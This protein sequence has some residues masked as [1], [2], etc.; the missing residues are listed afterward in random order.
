MSEA[1]RR[2]L[3]P[4]GDVNPR[5]G[6]SEL[7]TPA[8]LAT[9]PARHGGFRIRHAQGSGHSQ[10]QGDEIGVGIDLDGT[11]LVRRFDRRRLFRPHA[12]QFAR[13]RLSIYSWRP[14]AT[15]TST[16]TTR[17]R[18]PASSWARRSRR[19]K[20]ASPRAPLR[21]PHGRDPDP[22]RAGPVQPPLSDLKVAFAAQGRGDGHRAVRSSTRPSP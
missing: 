6:L 22:L 18:T 21:A 3:F 12:G 13:Q 20:P 16:C 15:C 8:R 9:P 7:P 17:W 14:R 19:R 2:L 11:G 4:V 5:N 10:D 1:G